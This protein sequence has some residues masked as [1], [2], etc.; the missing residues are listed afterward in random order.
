VE[1]AG[2]SLLYSREF[3]VTAK[4]RL[5]PDGILQQWLPG[6]AD[7]TV[8][9]S[10]AGALRDS[11]P[12]VRVFQSVERWGVHFLASRHPIAQRS[13]HELVLRM[14]P[15]ALADMM[16]W[17]PA[18]DADQQFRLVLTGEIP[19]DNVIAG[20]AAPSL[21]DDRPVNEYYLYRRWLRPL[22]SIAFR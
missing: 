8:R 16:E 19:V 17:G 1:A 4:K 18:S 9:S 22:A 20:A 10:V 3:Y 7:S 11:F 13:A 12:Y 14:P 2:S 15:A 21:E 5:R 6:G